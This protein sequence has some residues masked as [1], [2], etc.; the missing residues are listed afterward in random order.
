MGSFNDAVCDFIAFRLC[1][2]GRDRNY[3]IT[4]SCFHFIREPSFQLA[5]GEHTQLVYMHWLNNRIGDLLTFG[6]LIFGPQEHLL[7]A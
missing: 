5:L 7:H 2:V 4:I 6:M 3:S 1:G